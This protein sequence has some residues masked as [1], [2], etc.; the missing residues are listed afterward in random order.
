MSSKYLQSVVPNKEVEIK[1]E[2]VACNALTV[3]GVPITGGGSAPEVQ[4][5]VTLDLKNQ[6]LTPVGSGDVTIMSL[7][8]GEVGAQMNQWYMSLAGITLTGMSSSSFIG[9]FSPAINH[10]PNSPVGAKVV[11]RNTST[12]TLATG[13]LLFSDVS[14]QIY[15]DSPLPMGN[16]QLL[17]IGL[18]Y[19]SA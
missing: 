13:N 10:L 19:V 12:F 1:A 7:P 8:I 3:D 17:S 15:M 18:V 2:S 9:T 14:F 11:F 5:S 6:S 4:L 16:Y